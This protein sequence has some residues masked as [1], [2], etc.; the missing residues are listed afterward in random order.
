[1]TK[2]FVKNIIK[3][4]KKL[5][6]NNDNKL[7]ED[8]NSITPIKINNSNIIELSED[9][10]ISNE[11]SMLEIN[12]IETKIKTLVEQNNKDILNVTKTPK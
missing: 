8:L 6:I 12:D 3:P 7:L 1:M 11:I 4:V 5:L 10:N 2:K 9:K